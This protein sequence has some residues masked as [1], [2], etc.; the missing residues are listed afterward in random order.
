MKFFLRTEDVAKGFEMSP[1]ESAAFGI[2]LVSK[3]YQI[4]E[5]HLTLGHL[6][7][8]KLIWLHGQSEA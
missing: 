1:I 3:S 5:K 6:G 8:H 2:P 4:F 7:E